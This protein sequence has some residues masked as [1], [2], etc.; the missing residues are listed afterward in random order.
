MKLQI[1]VEEE[2]DGRWIAE[3]VA[4]RRL[5]GHVDFKLLIPAFA[6]LVSC[7][8]TRALPAQSVD[9]LRMRLL[10]EVSEGTHP[11]ADSLGQLSGIA[12]DRAGNVYVSDFSDAGIW[13]FDASGRSMPAIGRRGKGPGEFSKPTGIA[14]GPDGRLYVRDL[15]RVSRFAVDPAHGRL[16]RYDRSFA[17]PSRNDWTSM[18]ASRFD[19]AGRLYYPA[20]NLIDRSV[21]TGFYLVYSPAGVLED[22]LEVPAFPGAPASTASVRLSAHGGR[23]LNGVNHVPFAPLPVWDVTPRGTLI[24]G[25]AHTYVIRETDAAGKMVREFRRTI[26]PEPIP[27]RE[28]RDSVA[29][30]RAR[31][32]SIP[33]PSSQVEGVPPDVRALRVPK[34]YPVFTAAYAAAD[35]TVWVRRWSARRDRTVFDVFQ[36]NGRFRTVVELPRWILPLPTPV[37]SLDGIAAIGVDA[38]T[39]AHI[40]LRFGPAARR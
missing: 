25:D 39:G 34:T 17:S 28:W 38:E 18:L 27:A 35:G 40:I 32:D 21:R 23:M 20:F 14:I 24:T 6:I 4:L 7:A 29:A 37:L 8:M 26:A 10:W 30:L 12:L 16:T 9:T 13:V 1:A 22:S 36:A 15:E 19:N 5:V 2:T 33:G 11:T 3:M 31:V